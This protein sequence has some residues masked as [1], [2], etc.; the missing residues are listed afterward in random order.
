MNFTSS[1]TDGK[2]PLLSLAVILSR[3]ISRVSILTRDTDIAN[4]S[5]RLSVTFGYQMK[6]A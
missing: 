6:T 5:V 3:F 2:L 1:V 4:M